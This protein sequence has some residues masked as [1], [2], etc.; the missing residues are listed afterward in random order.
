MPRDDAA[1]VLDVLLAARKAVAFLGDL[2]LPAFLEDEKT[3]AAVL[4][5]LL[6]VGEAVKR[7][8]DEFRS[9]RPDV[10][11]KK[12][13]GMRDVL[14]HAYDA[15]DIESVYATIKRDLPGLIDRLP[16]AHEESQSTLEALADEALAE[17][18]G[19]LTEP[20]N[21]EECGRK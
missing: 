11:W 13:A 3:Q 9:A 21:P 14:I 15:V 16:A 19:G 6:V 18:R 12:I 10:P 7:L 8:S 5:Q 4:H 2:A 17:H 20:L 1:T